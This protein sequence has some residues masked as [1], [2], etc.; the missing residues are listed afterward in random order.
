MAYKLGFKRIDG[1]QSITA[2]EFRCRHQPALRAAAT[3]LLN[4]TRRGGGLRIDGWLGHPC[5][6]RF[7][8]HPAPS[9]S[10]LQI[11]FRTEV[12]IV[13]RSQR[14]MFYFAYHSMVFAMAFETC[15]QPPAE[16]PE[17]L[18]A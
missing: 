14:R 8:P 7:E 11:P 10:T 12:R 9:E 1:V 3:L 15:L 6:M 18:K 4:F 17:P 5:G 2:P 13:L 16:P